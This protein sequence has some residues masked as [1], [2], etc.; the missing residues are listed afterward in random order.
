MYS[1]I[2]VKQAFVETLQIKTKFLG[3]SIMGS[4]LSCRKVASTE[5]Q[6]ETVQ[7]RLNVE[8]DC[9]FP[10]H[11]ACVPFT[12][13][14]HFPAN[15]DANITNQ[16][17]PPQK[18]N[19]IIG[20]IRGN[21]CF[22]ELN[23]H[24]TGNSVNYKSFKCDYNKKFT[25]LK[26]IGLDNAMYTHSYLVQNNK[27][28]VVFKKNQCY[29][30]YDLEN[31]IWLLKKGEKKLKHVY[32]HGSRSVLIND[33]ILLISQHNQLQFY[34]IGNHHVTNPILIEKY[35]LKTNNVS[36]IQHGMCLIDLIKQESSQNQSYQ[37]YTFKIFLFGGYN[38]D[39]L[40]SFLCLDVLLSYQNVALANLSIDESII[41]IVN[42]CMSLFV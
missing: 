8:Y 24:D 38:N 21:E 41:K 40:K 34:F 28:I 39:F 11:V 23:V 29:N 3:Q 10:I 5:S 14:S 6:L 19:I 18:K 30:V 15:I 9:D 42:N 37:T 4:S 31:D 17:S 27:Y 1:F 22:Y 36:F 16:K 32:H 2:I 26:C 20:G 13:Y 25:N 12:G 7:S 35:T 33:E